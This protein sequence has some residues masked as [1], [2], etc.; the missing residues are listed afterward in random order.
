MHTG[1]YTQMY[2]MH[3]PVRHTKGKGN[4][5]DYTVEPV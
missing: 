5:S 2:T 4:V 1:S 3:E